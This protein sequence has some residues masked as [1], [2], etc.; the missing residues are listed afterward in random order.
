[1]EV[2]DLHP[3]DHRIRKI[4]ARNVLSRQRASPISI[5]KTMSQRESA[6]ARDIEFPL[7]SPLHDTFFHDHS[8]M[9][10]TLAH[11]DLIALN[12]PP[13]VGVDG[14]IRNGGLGIRD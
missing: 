13:G 11:D 4:E 12:G 6:E 5:R 1:M 8:I 3:I 14:P 10:P 7:P 9:R 2:P